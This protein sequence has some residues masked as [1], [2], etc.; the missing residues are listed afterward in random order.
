[1]LP[2]GELE[3][4]PTDGAGFV[5]VGDVGAVADGVEGRVAGVREV[6]DEGKVT[7]AGGGVGSGDT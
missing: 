4:L 6:G 5:V 7:G 2:A 1:M 3:L